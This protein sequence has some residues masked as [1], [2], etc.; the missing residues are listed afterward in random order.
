VP[1]LVPLPRRSDEEE[2]VR[3]ENVSRRN[4]RAKSRVTKQTVKKQSTARKVKTAGQAADTCD[5]IESSLPTDVDVLPPDNQFLPTCIISVEKG[6][7]ELYNHC[8]DF[9]LLPYFCE[10]KYF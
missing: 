6:E 10:H 5:P 7:R 2:K 4:E 9:S 3:K 8:P 1:Q